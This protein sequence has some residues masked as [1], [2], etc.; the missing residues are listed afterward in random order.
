MKPH[1]RVK[2]VW[3]KKSRKPVKQFFSSPCLKARARKQEQ[4]YSEGKIAIALIDY[5]KFNRILCVILM[6]ITFNIPFCYILNEF[7]VC[8]LLRILLIVVGEVAKAEG[9]ATEELTGLEGGDKCRYR[10]SLTWKN[11]N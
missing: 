11:M 4:K 1:L 7:Q 10:K 5:Q 3:Q 2:C 6:C 9:S 8:Y